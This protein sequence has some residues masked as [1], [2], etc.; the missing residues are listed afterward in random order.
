[1]VKAEKNPNGRPTKYKAEY[2]DQ[3][4]KLCL[5]GL[6]DAQLSQSFMVSEVT[7]NAWKKKHPNFLKSLRAG[8]EIA[9]A[10]VAG[11]LYERACGYEHPEDKV[12]LRNKTVT[13]GR[14]DDTEVITSSEVV[15]VPTT[16][17]YPP[18]TAAAIIWLKNRQRG[19]WRDRQDVEYNI[20]TRTIADIFALVSAN[21][22]KL[23]NPVKQIES[24][25][26]DV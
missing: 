1:M 22:A 15:T 14:G 24:E 11:S 20:G 19:H 13:K 21:R 5:L 7:L 4:Y 25:V 2:A 9:D 16:K 10:E 23:P 6:S 18:D 12:F 17:H 3:A 26:V 8:K